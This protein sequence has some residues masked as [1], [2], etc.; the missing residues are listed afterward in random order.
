MASLTFHGGVGEIG[1]NKVLLEHDGK[2]LWFDFGMSFGQSGRYFSEYLQPKKFNGVTDYLVTGLLPGLDDMCGLYRQDYL[3]HC[4]MQLVE[5]PA[6]DA[7]FLSHAHADHASYV[8]FLRKDIPVYSSEVT[9]R[10]LYAIEETSASG[11]CD[12]TVFR[13]SFLLR[14]KKRGEGMTKAKGEETR[15]QRDFRVLEDYPGPVEIGG[16]AIEGVP[17]NHSLPGARAYIVHTSDGAIVY[18]GDLRFHGYGGAFTESFVERACSVR[19]LALV[20]EGTRVDQRESA[21][22]E[23]VR[24]RVAEIARDRSLVVANFP[25]RDTER[26]SS[27][28]DVARATGRKLAISTKQAFLLKQLEGTD[29]GAPSPNDESIAIYVRR[30]NWG[31]ITKRGRYPEEIMLQDYDKWE[32]EFLDYPNAVT[33]EDISANQTDFIVRIDFF[34]L[35]D[36][37]SLRPAEGSCY[38]RSVTEPHDEEDEIDLKRAQ[39]WLKL[40][41]LFPYEQV[42]AS[43]HLSGVELQKLIHQVRPKMLIPVHTEKPEAFLDLAPKGTEVVLPELGKRIALSR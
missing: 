20:C 34:E 29:A 43:G 7:V 24:D 28:L 4:D 3:A 12:F 30:K 15:S 38:I 35:P 2:R 19:P 42:H 9:R 11:S 22:E 41:G 5:Q 10:I 36:L 33:C 6:Y 14:E 13:E 23:Y 21:S 17:V 40:F 27:F 1:G 32:L 8:H 37:I 25:I 16:M 39:E 31:L 26:M 18:T